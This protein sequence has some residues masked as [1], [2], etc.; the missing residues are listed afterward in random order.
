M[1]T[2]KI[3]ESVAVQTNNVPVKLSAVLK[4]GEFHSIGVVLNGTLVPCQYNILAKHPDGSIRHALVMFWLNTTGVVGTVHNVVLDP[5]QQLL[6]TGVAIPKKFDFATLA[7]KV[8]IVDSQDITWTKEVTADSTWPILRDSLTQPDPLDMLHGPL[9]NEVEYITT[10]DSLSGPHPN[11]NLVARWRFFKDW[12]GVR[13]E[14]VF[15]ASKQTALADIGT[16]SITIWLDGQP[17]F[18]LPNK[19]IGAGQRFRVVKWVGAK[20]PI[21]DFDVRQDRVYLRDMNVVPLYDLNH[22]LGTKD[23]DTVIGSFFK[24]KALDPVNY[25]QGLPLVNGILVANQNQTGDRADIDPQPDWATCTWNSEDPRAAQVQM[26]ADGNSAGAFPVHIRDP[27]SDEMGLKYN[28][29]I[30]Q[31]KG[32]WNNPCIPNRAHHALVGFIS[33]VKI[34]REWNKSK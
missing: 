24:N 14:F 15:E 23:V 5:V 7:C 34:I 20:P 33:Y 12:P 2:F 17:V 30:T 16:K 28:Y 11:L 29:H 18:S 8:Q 19:T 22:P 31:A 25:D 13:V 6:A 1:S 9:A 4:E 26:A 32:K 27:N 21:D 3:T 10:L